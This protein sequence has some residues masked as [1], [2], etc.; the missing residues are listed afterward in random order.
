MPMR[1]QEDYHLLNPDEVVFQAG[2]IM[3]NRI[4]ELLE[5]GKTFAFETTLATKS[6]ASFIKKAK[7]NGYEIILFFLKLNSENWLLNELRRVF[8]KEVITSQKK[9]LEGDSKMD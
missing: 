1:L 4:N 7:E 9:L 2:R 3:I 6:Y 8:K 5:E